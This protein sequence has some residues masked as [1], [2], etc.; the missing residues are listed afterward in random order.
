MRADRV[1]PTGAE[2]YRK[3]ILGVV[4]EAL[5]A[6]AREAVVVSGSGP[7]QALLRG[8]L[9]EGGIPVHEPT[10]SEEGL[11]VGLMGTD[12]T[13]DHLFHPEASAL[14][15]QALAWREGFLSL[16]TTNKTC[17]LLAP[18]QPIQAILPLGDVFASEIW[19]LAGAATVPPVLEGGTLADLRRVDQAVDSYYSGG[20]AADTAFGA[21]PPALRDEVQKAWAFSRKGWHPRPLIP[22][23]GKA[24]LGLDLDP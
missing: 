4:R 2:R 12:G 19:D 23:L 20:V 15:G 3:I 7:E 22:K 1:D 18:R 14:A 17:L 6:T 16:G 24:T 10:A 21:L 11:G 8:W 9:D 13:P 5:R